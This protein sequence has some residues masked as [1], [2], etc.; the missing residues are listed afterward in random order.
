[1][2]QPPIQ[3]GELAVALAL[4]IGVIA[5]AVA[6]HLRI[7]AIVIL[8]VAGVALGPDF[9]GII[10]PSAVGEGLPALVG[11]AVAI[12]LFEG[13][14][15]LNLRRLRRAGPALRRLL[16]IG[17]LV[18][19]A[20]GSV[21]AH[22]LLSWPWKTSILFGTLVVVTGPTVVTPLVRRLK[23]ERQVSA[24]L[25]VE[26]VLI[27]AIGAITAVVALDLAISPGEGDLVFGAGDILAR[28]GIGSAIG[29]ATGLVIAGLLRARRVVP[30]GLE[31]I[32]T[33]GFVLSSFFLCN[34]VLPESGLAAV[35]IAGIVLANL[36]SRSSH[37]LLEFKEQ[38]TQMFIG[39]LFVL[40]AADVRVSDVVALGW[41][42]VLT[43][44]A[45]VFVVRPLNVAVSSFGTDLSARKRVFLA[46]IAPRGIVAAAV[47]S[48][49]ANELVLHDV[50]GGAQLRALVFLTI[51]ITVAQAGLTGGIVAR[52]LGLKLGRGEGWVLLGANELARAV[53]VALRDSGQDVVLLDSNPDHCRVATESGLRALSGN[54]LDER[55]LAQASI[56]TRRGVVAMAPNETINLRF[57]EAALTECRELHA[58][59]AL[60]TSELNVTPAQAESA[61]TSVLFG[62]ERDLDTWLVDLRQGAAATEVWELQ[63]GAEAGDE[64]RSAGREPLS[65][66][67]L[68]LY[69]GDDAM[70]VDSTTDYREGDRVLFAISAR[71][72]A[73]ARE[74]LRW[75]GWARPAGAEGT[76]AT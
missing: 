55:T 39:M 26:G 20:G 13:G 53:A 43:V 70:P 38:L 76:N 4:G 8:L 10:H 42:G 40:L 31:N 51:A 74:W 9:G 57:A 68:V 36:P 58:S 22:L 7:P 66:L 65:V 44:L 63:P 24:L 47:A 50:D 18:T 30:E 11:F 69:R 2:L 48:H 52:L 29:V 60:I 73:E 5:Q 71:G 25:E 32:F 54:A 6:H 37:A 34:A 35:T 49:F 61:G 14:L 12:I 33:L 16:S 17:A 75:W 19:L 28:L 1:M 15:N 46:W 64:S 41:P 23:V 62:R 67:P 72:R 3:S 21:A 59:I 56:D 45:L 27:D